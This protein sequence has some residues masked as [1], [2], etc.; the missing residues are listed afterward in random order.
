MIGSRV[1]V[2]L[3]SNSRASVED[4]FAARVYAPYLGLAHVVGYTKPPAKD[5]SGF[6]FR[7][8]YVG[9]DG[10]EQI[11]NEQLAG[12]NGLRLTETRLPMTGAST[13]FYGGGSLDRRPDGGS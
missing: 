13:V 9:I 2:P 4:D 1:A 7:E 12:Q 8:T 3:T 6:Y 5:T 11:F 10:I